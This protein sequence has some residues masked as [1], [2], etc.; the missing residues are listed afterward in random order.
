MLTDYLLSERQIDTTMVSYSG[1]GGRDKKEVGGEAGRAGAGEV[2]DL[3]HWSQ[4][5][6]PIR[7]VSR[8]EK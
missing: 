8:C 2:S 3:K 5:A 4:K 7:T 6:G 1:P